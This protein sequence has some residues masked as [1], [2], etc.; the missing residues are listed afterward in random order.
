VGHTSNSWQNLYKQSLENALHEQ[1]SFF[2]RRE[3]ATIELMP[4]W[5]R[6][7]GSHAAKL[8]YQMK[9]TAVSGEFTIYSRASWGKE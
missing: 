7:A 6:S 9:L 1:P 5:H 2:A 3:V 8:S 4:P